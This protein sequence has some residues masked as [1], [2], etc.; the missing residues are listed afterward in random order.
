M[1]HYD[2]V[3]VGIPHDLKVRLVQHRQQKILVIDDKTMYQYH[4][5]LSFNHPKV[6][7]LYHISKDLEPDEQISFE[8]RAAFFEQVV[9]NYE[10]KAQENKLEQRDDLAQKEVD[11]KSGKVE[12]IG[13][14]Q[15]RLS[16]LDRV[17]EISYNEVYLVKKDYRTLDRSNPFV[18]TFGDLIHFQE[19]PKSV[20]IEMDSLQALEVAYLW[21]SY[22]SQVSLL[23]TKNS[24]QEVESLYFRDGIR[25]R[26]A[27]FGIEF[28][29]LAQQIKLQDKHQYLEVT[30]ISMNQPKSLLAEV[31][32][33]AGTEVDFS[34]YY[35][36]TEASMIID[37]NAV[38][39]FEIHL[40]PAFVQVGKADKE[41]DLIIQKEASQLTYFYSNFDFKGGIELSFN[42]KTQQ[43]NAGTFYCRDAHSIAD[44][45]QLIKQQKLSLVDLAHATNSSSIFSIFKEFAVAILEEV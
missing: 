18:Y 25:D 24:L 39:Y 31:Y 10:Q 5:G 1:V 36:N 43:F 33:V 19:L 13:N 40:N 20:V 44:S 22:G 35:G 9:L 27:E 37:E 6:E 30:F 12:L 45:F 2:V 26:L 11:F 41:N 14:Q 7:M 8:D 28:Y 34:A 15:L 4:Q 29:P 16:W 38:P 3:Y 21:A 32:F 23:I 42:K 17:E